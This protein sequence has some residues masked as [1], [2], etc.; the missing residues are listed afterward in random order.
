MKITV[1]DMFHFGEEIRIG[2]LQIVFAAVWLEGVL[3]Q[4]SLYGRP[5]DR[6]ADGLGVFFEIAVGI[7]Q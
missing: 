4:D 5:T 6:A 1:N 2:D 3:G 7:T